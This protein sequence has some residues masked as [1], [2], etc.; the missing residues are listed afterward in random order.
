[1]GRIWSMHYIGMLAF[2]LPIPVWYD[3]PIV[4]VSLIAAIVASGVALHVAS[5]QGMSV[6]HAM[7]GSA[8]MGIG[9]GA[10]HYIGMATMRMRAMCH[11]TSGLLPLPWS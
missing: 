2:R 6:V 3:W 4:L 5:G 10:M 1:M 9:I 7:T 8:V 11:L